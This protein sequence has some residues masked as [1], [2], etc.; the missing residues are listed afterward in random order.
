[1]PF[2]PP[3][4]DPIFDKVLPK[5]LSIADLKAARSKWEPLV[6]NPTED[7]IAFM[8]AD[9]EEYRAR[10]EANNVCKDVIRDIFQSKYGYGSRYREAIKPLIDELAAQGDMFTLSTNS[11]RSG[12]VFLARQEAARL[13]EITH[14]VSEGWFEATG[15]NRPRDKELGER[16]LTEAADRGVIQGVSV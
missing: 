1:L 11:L 16:Y 2:K 14:M 12:N 8:K 15:F 4:H 7:D 6:T 13:G 10:Y 3:Y 5:D 9:I